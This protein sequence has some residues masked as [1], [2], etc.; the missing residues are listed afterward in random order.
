MDFRESFKLFPR[1]LR[2]I[3]GKVNLLSI[4]LGYLDTAC[5]LL[6]KKIRREALGKKRCKLLKTMKSLTLPILSVFYAEY[7]FRPSLPCYSC[8]SKVSYMGSHIF[9]HPFPSSNI[10]SNTKRQI[11]WRKLL[12]PSAVKKLKH[13][14]IQSDIM[15]EKCL[16]RDCA[17]EE[18]HVPNF[19]FNLSALHANPLS[20]G[21]Q[22]QLVWDSLC[23]HVE[24][25]SQ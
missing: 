8:F 24:I 17:R 16:N 2:K 6:W 22:K 3:I 15:I 13:F 25:P 20:H 19:S 4:P 23:Y 9:F 5:N 10:C 1:R 12:H 18:T 7:Y 21:K 11:P 14:H